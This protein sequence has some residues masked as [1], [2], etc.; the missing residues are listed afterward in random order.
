M[1]THT[2]PPSIIS[3]TSVPFSLLYNSSIAPKSGPGDGPVRKLFHGWSRMSSQF[4][5]WLC[6]VLGFH[7]PCFPCSGHCLASSALLETL[8]SSRIPFVSIGFYPAGRTWPMQASKQKPRQGIRRPAA[9]PSLPPPMM[10]TNQQTQ[11]QPPNR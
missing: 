4:L 8:S 3:I 5:S 2:P 9:P 11:Q 1:Y 6:L 7:S 10:G